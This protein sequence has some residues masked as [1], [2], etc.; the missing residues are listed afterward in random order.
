MHLLMHLLFA[1]ALLLGLLALLLCVLVLLCGRAPDP[2]DAL[3]ADGALSRKKM[4]GLYSQYTSATY[5]VIFMP[6]DSALVMR[7]HALRGNNVGLIVPMLPRL[8]QARYS[9][10]LWQ[11]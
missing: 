11:E 3:T 1:L 10:Y 2:L 6:A 4:W 9:L 8:M 7:L 5:K